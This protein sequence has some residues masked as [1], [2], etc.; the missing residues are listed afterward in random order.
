MQPLVK[1]NLCGKVLE[2]VDA[3]EHRRLTG[4]NSWEMIER[5]K[6]EQ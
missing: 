6:E 3:P 2:P 5:P 4:H 1:C